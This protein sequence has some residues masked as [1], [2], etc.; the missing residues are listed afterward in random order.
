MDGWLGVVIM[1]RATAG[2]RKPLAIMTVVALFLPLLFFKYTNFFYSDI[3]GPLIG[4]HD[5]AIDL[6]LPLGIS[7]IT[8]TLTAYVVDTYRG[9]FPAERRISMPSTTATSATAATIRAI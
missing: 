5:R 1:E 4:R 6:A 8:F 2:W 9:A 7:F 3:L